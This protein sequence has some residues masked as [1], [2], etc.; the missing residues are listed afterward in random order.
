M[1]RLDLHAEVTN[2][3]KS[4]G[5]R[6]TLRTEFVIINRKKSFPVTALINS[7]CN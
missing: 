5:C 6:R 3:D 2:S 7:I 4:A 1:E